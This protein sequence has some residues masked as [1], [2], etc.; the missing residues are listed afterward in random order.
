MARC[1]QSGQQ[2]LTLVETLVCATLFAVLGGAALNAMTTGQLLFATNEVVLQ[3]Q[4]RA[5]NALDAIAQDLTDAQLYSY[6]NGGGGGKL[7]YVKFRRLQNI[8]IDST[9]ILQWDNINNSLM[10]MYVW[11]PPAAMT[12][13]PCARILTFPTGV[14]TDIAG[15]G[16]LL[17]IT[18]RLGNSDGENNLSW[19][20]D[21]VLAPEVTGFSVNLFFASDGTTIGRASDATCSNNVGTPFG[22]APSN[23]ASEQ[24]VNRGLFVTPASA[25]GTSD[26]LPVTVTVSLTTQARTSS[27]RVATST[28]QTS[29][30]L[31]N[32]QTPTP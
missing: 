24:C 31:R 21:R 15:V 28:R 32:Q 7:Y 1:R 3:A 14:P 8:F 5:R 25:F 20:V 19:A 16:P 22:P 26:R 17:L 10:R 12:M 2:G 29:I 11:C 4:Q 27:G 30:Q 13:D 6:E 9:G 18:P 23:N